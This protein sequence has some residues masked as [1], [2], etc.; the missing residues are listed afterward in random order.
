VGLV[1]SAF[2]LIGPS[3]ATLI[4]N[5]STIALATYALK[6]IKEV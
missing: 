3:I 1:G 2:G 4:N 6:K 5:G